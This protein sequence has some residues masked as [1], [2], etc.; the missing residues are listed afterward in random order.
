[1]IR[2]CF[3]IGS[4]RGNS[5]ILVF[6][7]G[8]ICLLISNKGKLCYGLVKIYWLSYVHKLKKI[9]GDII[10][11]YHQ[12]AKT[13]VTKMYTHPFFGRNSLLMF[14]FLFYDFWYLFTRQLYYAH[15]INHVNIFSHRNINTPHFKF[16]FSFCYKIKFLK[17][18]Q[19]F[20][21]L[22]HFIIQ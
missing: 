13:Q 6:K 1:L 12:A 5:F 18:K 17:I 8:L 14:D 7:A 3:S 22:D 21:D 9:V 4:S 10:L 11:S 19:P 15:E 16:Y 20:A 2:C